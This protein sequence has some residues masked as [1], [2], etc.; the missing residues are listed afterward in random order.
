MIEALIFYPL[1]LMI[2]VCVCVVA[3][4][5]QPVQQVCALIGACVLMSVMWLLMHAEFLAL[6]LV[7][8]Y[9]GAVM[10]LFLYVVMMIGDHYRY[11]NVRSLFWFSYVGYLVCGGLLLWIVHWIVPSE[12]HRQFAMPALS[13]PGADFSLKSLG[14]V[15][16]GSYPVAFECAAF[17]LLIAMMSC[18]FLVF[19]GQRQGRKTQIIRDQIRVTKSD[20]LRL[21]RDGDE[22]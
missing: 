12:V 4:W 18:I 15:L 16:F 14:Q 7:F 1:A 20:R 19:R 2:L 3:F 13:A 10:T 9:V 5:Q 21:V 8:V 22:K 11:P 17:L 6:L